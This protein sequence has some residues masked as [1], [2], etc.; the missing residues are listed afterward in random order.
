MIIRTA[1]PDDIEALAGLIHKKNKKPATQC[2]H[3]STAENSQGIGDEIRRWLE[4]GEVMY[5]IAA[6]NG[7]IRAAAGCEYDVELGRG[8]LRGPFSEAGDEALAAV[9]FD[10]LLNELP[11]RLIRLDSFL[12]IEN[13][14]GTAFYEARGYEEASRAHVYAAPR[15]GRPDRAQSPKFAVG[16]LPAGSEADLAELHDRTFPGTYYSGQALVENQNDSHRLFVISDHG[17]ING[18]LFGEIEPE[19]EE[20]YVDFLGVRAEARRQGLGGALLQ[21]ALTWF[22]DD[23][24]VPAVGLTVDDSNIN[25]RGL[26]ERVG[27]SLKYS[28]VNTRWTRPS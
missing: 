3:S 7:K 21:A 6:D 25:A 4:S 27:F 23:L 20:G 9:A 26:Y 1:K 19:S 5:A 28:G 8:W 22:F 2:I 11:E 15:V 13:S 10:H 17:Q 16:S 14:A 18:Y 12:N 24:K